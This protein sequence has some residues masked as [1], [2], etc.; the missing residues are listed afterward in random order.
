MHKLCRFQKDGGRVQVGVITELGS[1]CELGFAGISTLTEILEASDPAA[2]VEELLQDDDLPTHSLADI[3]LLAPIEGQEVWA[4]GVT[5]LRS[6]TARM[7]ES[8]F[9]ANAYDRV[10]AADRPEIFLKSLPEKVVG[11]GDEV[12]IREDAKWNVPEPELALVI[13]SRKK[14]VGY[15][16][17]NDMSSRDIEGENLLY[18]PQAKVYDKSCAMGPC[19][20]IGPSEAEVRAWTIGVKISRDGAAVFEGETTIDQIKRSFDELAG[21]LC[22]SQSFPMGAALLTGTGVVPGDD[23]TLAVGDVVTIDISGI[24]TLENT[25]AVV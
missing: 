7:G 12:G 5:Y 22:R 24:G 21:Y 14:V 25:V 19:I 20:V 16:I 3:T 4:A 8:D 13:N 23:F 6:K 11:P 18:L 9:S 15:T 2:R 1:V 10:Y 17:G